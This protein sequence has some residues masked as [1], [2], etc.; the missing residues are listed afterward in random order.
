MFRLNA[1]GLPDGYR[2]D[3][4]PFTSCTW[5]EEWN[6]AGSMQVTICMDEAARGID[7][8][9]IL[10][11][12]RTML[13]LFDGS[14]LVHAGPILESP[15]WDGS[16]LTVSVG[17]G[18]SL[19]DS[20]L[21]LDSR[22]R[23]QHIQGYVDLGDEENPPTGW[24]WSYTGNPGEVIR[25]LIEE[26]GQ[27]GRIPV[28]GQRYDGNVK[29][30]MAWNGWEFVTVADA[31]RDVL[32]TEHGGQL[33]F[34]PELN[35]YGSLG[36]VARW[37]ETGVTDRSRPFRWN[38]RSLD[39]GI[40]FTGVGSSGVRLANQ[41]WANGGKANDRTVIV[42]VDNE[43]TPVGEPLLQVGDSSHNTDGSIDRLRSY[44]TGLL[45]ASRSDR[46]WN[47]KVRMDLRPHV[48][49]RVE[50]TVMDPYLH[51]LDQRDDPVPTTVGLIVT[52]VGG[53]VGDEWLT[54]GCKACGVNVNGVT[55][56][57]NDPTALMARQIRRVERLARRALSPSGTQLYQTV[58]RLQALT[59]G[60]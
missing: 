28:K 18:W 12:Q 58:S 51:E 21:V 55:S 38:D 6:E 3:R 1:Y 20:R 39:N 52:D 37:S 56:T 22:M 50:F 41:A 19:F 14:T 25:G 49:D 44:A 2:L 45:N 57:V 36:F 11:E 60:S 29:L 40:V 32:E 59:K 46:T 24:Q 10:L 4:I 33:R 48:G 27:W 16:L 13:A 30:S 5:H 26:T 54:V 31:F 42:R 9:A 53:T 34:D 23:D 7:L 43:R 15:T 47:F 8:D 35:A 17:G